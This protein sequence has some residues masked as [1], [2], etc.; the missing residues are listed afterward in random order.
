MVEKF[1]PICKQ[2]Y[3]ATLEYFYEH[4][5]NHSDGLYTYCKKC[6]IEK[7]K[8]YQ[9][10]Y[11]ADKVR[12][13][14]RKNYKREKAKNSHRESAK[15]QSLAGYHI[16]YRKNNKDKIKFYNE[17]RKNKNLRISKQEW[18]SCKNY[19]NNCCAY[20]GM[21]AAKHKELFNQDLHKEHVNCDGKNDLSNCVPSCKTCNSSKHRL[22][23]SEWYNEK[24]P[25]YFEE[26]ML[27]IDRWLKEEF[28]N[29]LTDT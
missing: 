11:D 1:C 22:D 17:K 19:F 20:C 9:R 4:K 13:N 21:S 7:H 12:A 25:I 6:T 23:I 16:R 26:R 3:P 10:K 24:N 28:K 14:S 15:R 27:K 29:Y 2:N 8:D 18:D 5:T